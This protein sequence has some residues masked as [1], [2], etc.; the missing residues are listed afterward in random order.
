MRITLEQYRMAKAA[1]D[2]TVIELASLAKVSTNT[3]VRFER[4]ERLT[5]RTMQRVRS[6]FESAGIEFIP[7]DGGGVG[8]RLRKGRS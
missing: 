6:A 2:L 7:E 8:I 3:L 1:L 5:E 4:G